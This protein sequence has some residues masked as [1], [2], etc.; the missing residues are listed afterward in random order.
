MFEENG[1]LRKVFGPKKDE[2]TGDWRRLHDEKLCDF[3]FSPNVTRVMKS[4]RMS[5]VGHERM[6]DRTGA[7]GFWRG[8]PRVRGHVEHRGVHGRVILKWIF[9]MC[10]GE[11]LIGLIWLR[12]GTGGGR[13]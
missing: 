11:A 1:I 12:I 3:T 4:I 2:V 5:W 8:D 9:K 13:F 10:D 7:C 6:G